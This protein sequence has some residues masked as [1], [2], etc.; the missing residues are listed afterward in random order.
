[1]N[2]FRPALPRRRVAYTPP[3]SDATTIFVLGLLGLLLCGILGIFAWVK[4]NDY[5]RQCRAFR[6]RPSGLAVAGRILGM[7]ATLLIL[8]QLVL[9]LLML[10]IV[11][12]GS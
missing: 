2:E 7:V 8:L 1:M 10:G 11:A 6:A 4:G 3:E 12:T 5:M 9:G